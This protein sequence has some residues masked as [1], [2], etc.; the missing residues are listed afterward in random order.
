[1]I[2]MDN[3]QRLKL[4]NIKELRNI[5]ELVLIPK[6]LLILGLVTSLRFGY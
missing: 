4:L 5:E 1:M 6:N 3:E 2:D